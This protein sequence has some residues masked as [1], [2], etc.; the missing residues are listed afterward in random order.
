M[1]N[2]KTTAM[3]I[4]FLI[5]GVMMFFALIVLSMSIFPKEVMNLACWI[6]FQS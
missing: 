2:M 3:M 4:E 5:A 1:Q 6:R